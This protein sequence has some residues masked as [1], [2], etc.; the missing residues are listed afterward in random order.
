MNI[1][2]KIFCHKYCSNGLEKIAL[3]KLE[4]VAL[5]NEIMLLKFDHFYIPWLKCDLRANS[6]AGL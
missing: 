4:R 3:R 5:K 1:D 6:Y 2:F